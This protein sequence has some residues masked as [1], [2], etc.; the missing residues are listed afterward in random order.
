MLSVLGWVLFVLEWVLS[1]L[2]W[3]LSV[4]CPWVGVVGELETTEKRTKG[5]LFFLLRPPKKVDNY[6]LPKRNVF[7]C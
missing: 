7:F 1:V 2:G 5:M 6:V 4:R 3:V